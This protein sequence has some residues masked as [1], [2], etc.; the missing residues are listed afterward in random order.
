MAKTTPRPPEGWRW[1]LWPL[2]SRKVQ[3]AVATIVVSYLAQAGIVLTPDSVIAV[4][5]V[6]VAMVLG[7]AIEDHGSKS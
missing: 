3:V 6:G 2:L 4:L 5:G 7:I 1:W